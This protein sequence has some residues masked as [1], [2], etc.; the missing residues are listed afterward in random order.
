MLCQVRHA[1]LTAVL[2]AVL[3]VLS[4]RSWHPVMPRRERASA[5]GAAS[6]VPAPKVARAGHYTGMDSSDILAVSGV[7]IAVAALAVSIYQSWLSRDHN[8]RSVRPA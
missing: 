3:E 6:V 1:D 2:R 8:R 7:V 5:V 4:T